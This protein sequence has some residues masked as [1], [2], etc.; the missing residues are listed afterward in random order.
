[1]S[2][3]KGL[4]IRIDLNAYDYD[5][6]TALGIAS[7]EGHL[8]SVEYLVTHGAN[9]YHKDARGND[10]LGDAMRENRKDVIEYLQ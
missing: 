8:E 9:I 6:R 5:G 2:L 7:S 4:H 3:I 10:A 1:M